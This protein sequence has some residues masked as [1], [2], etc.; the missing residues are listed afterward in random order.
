MKRLLSATLFLALFFL[1]GCDLKKPALE[2]IDNEVPKNLNPV[3]CT[4]EAKLCSDGSAVGRSG[5][6][7]E[8]APCPA[9]GINKETT[10]LKVYFGNSNLNPNAANCNQVYPQERVIPVATSTPQ[11]ALRELFKGPTEIEKSQ[12]YFSFFSVATQNIFKGM[13]IENG[14]AYVNLKDIRQIIPNASTSCGS[15]EFLTELQ[16][17]LKQFSTINRVIFAFDGKPAAF[18]EWLQIGCPTENNLCDEAQFNF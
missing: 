8:F 9:E 13:K 5:P 14:V 16:D 1:G 2:N 15:A 6:N 10:I 11:L 7:C 12:G 17:T 4:A 3:A 18:Y